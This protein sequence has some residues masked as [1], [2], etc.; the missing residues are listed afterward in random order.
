MPHTRPSPDNT[1][2]GVLPRVGP[3]ASSKVATVVGF[4]DAVARGEIARALRLLGEDVR[5]FEAPGMP[6]ASGEPYHGASEVAAHVL[7]PINADIT[8]LRLT[9]HGVLDYGDT[10]IALGTY[11]GRATRT[12]A[13]LHLPYAHVWT[14]VADKVVE[15][16]QYTDT[17]AFKALLA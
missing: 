10:V 11:T 15:F 6:Y 8:D 17:A 1:W 4:Y 13:G 7:G 9:T 3:D 2:P 5:W 12:Q 14:F 16:R